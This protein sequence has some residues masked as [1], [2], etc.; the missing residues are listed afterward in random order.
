MVYAILLAAGS[1][2]AAWRTGPPKQFLSL[3]GRPVLVHALAAFERA[4]QVDRVV[5]VSLAD[6]VDRCREMVRRWGIR[7]V[8]AVVKGGARRQDSVAQ[9][10]RCGTGRRERHRGPRRGAA[11]DTARTDRRCHRSCARQ[12]LGSAGRARNGY[13]QGDRKRARAADAGPV[14]DVAGPDAPGVSRVNIAAARTR[15][16]QG[17]DTWVRTTRRSSNG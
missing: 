13:R 4:R 14:A 15:R 6:R 12:R 8:A 2:A 17:R 10:T 5:L 7:K 1:A 16:R 3:A 11:A 9:G